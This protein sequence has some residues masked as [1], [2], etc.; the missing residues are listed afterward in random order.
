MF[1]VSCSSSIPSSLWPPSAPHLAHQ[2]SE[3]YEPTKKT[4]PGGGQSIA[5]G[6]HE[7][8]GREGGREREEERED[9]YA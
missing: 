9:A 5:P 7:P 8:V 2:Q 4:E 3:G 1:P 6:L